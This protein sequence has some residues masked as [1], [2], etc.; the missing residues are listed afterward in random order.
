MAMTAI[1]N[2]SLGD[3]VFSLI[4]AV[5]LMPLAKA[6]EEPVVERVSVTGTAE[7]RDGALID[8]CRLA[9]AKVHG[10]RVVGVLFKTNEKSRGFKETRDL[11]ALSFDGILTKYEI[12]N[13]S[14]P[15]LT[16]K[17]WSIEIE[18]S[19]L[20][21]F[22]DRFAGRV[23]VRTPTNADLIRSG[24]D[25]GISQNVS[26]GISQWFANSK[27]F[28]L[29]EREQEQMID[30]ELGRAATDDASARE[31][32][33]LSGQK[34][35]DI[36][37]LTEGGVLTFTEHSTSFKNISR[38]SHTCTAQTNLTIKVIDVMTKGEIGREELVISVKKSS[39]D[40]QESRMKA[41][42]ALGDALQ[43]N[44][45]GMGLQILSHLEC[46]KL[47]VDQD[48]TVH[49]ISPATGVSLK[50]FNIIR[51]SQTQEKTK[52][53]KIFGEFKL[54]DSGSKLSFELTKDEFPF[55][56]ILE[57][58]PIKQKE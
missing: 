45:S 41:L 19:V 25:Q 54:I 2:K 34:I 42:G 49:L 31:K 16:R 7:T 47:K 13:E 18:A 4:V 38:Q 24:M 6:N 58:Y 15:G 53:S 9:I 57:F 29:L 26:K 32:S 11:T 40:A 22:P 35:A 36:V 8:A 33:R 46:T 21:S 28:A 23:M 3:L 5:M 56:E 39:G 50:N 55:G 48:G 14:Q 30:D 1:F 43:E 52:D 51:L 12:K 20:R 37:I 27:Q 17:L 10:S 44:L